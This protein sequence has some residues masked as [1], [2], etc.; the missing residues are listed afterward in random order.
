MK[1]NSFIYFKELSNVDRLQ[2]AGFDT[3]LFDGV[4]I[5][6]LVGEINRRFGIF[7]RYLFEIGL[8]NLSMHMSGITI[9]QWKY[10]QYP[11]RQILEVKSSDG[12]FRLNG[13]VRS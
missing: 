8:V 11:T 6:I 7:N 9:T 10:P 13:E 12:I 1:K 4:Q 5:E 3:A 2:L